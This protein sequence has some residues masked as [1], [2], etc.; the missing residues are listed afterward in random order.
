MY[1]KSDWLTQGDTPDTNFISQI[2]VR[3]GS[4]HLLWKSFS[5]GK[6]TPLVGRKLYTVLMRKVEWNKS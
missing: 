6:V 5:P 3:K 4:Y 1:C 2:N